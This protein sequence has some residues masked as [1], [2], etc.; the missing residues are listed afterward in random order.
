MRIVT[1]LLAVVFFW[2]I[3]L[4]LSAQ[5]PFPDQAFEFWF[6]NAAMLSGSMLGP[7]GSASPSGTLNPALRQP[8][9]DT[10]EAYNRIIS[11]AATI[12][13][14]RVRG[15]LRVSGSQDTW[16]CIDRGRS[17]PM[18]PLLS[19]IRAGVSI[20]SPTW[21]SPEAVTGTAGHRISV[22]PPIHPEIHGCTVST[23]YG[24]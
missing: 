20:D 2:L 8:G 11:N 12:V 6:G 10:D 4:E 16:L 15:E 13:V 3:P 7:L 1:P 19:R 5:A 24:G 22:L 23:R 21:T 14:G 9:G 18:V 17:F